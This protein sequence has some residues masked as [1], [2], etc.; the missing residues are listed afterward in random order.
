MGELS[1]QVNNSINSLKTVIPEII[2]QSPDEAC[3]TIIK[4]LLSNYI[5]NDTNVP[6]LISAIET[7]CPTLVQCFSNISINTLENLSNSVNQ[8]AL[9]NLIIAAIISV[10]SLTNI[11]QGLQ[12]NTS[13]STIYDASFLILVSLLMIILI[14]KSQGFNEFLKNQTNVD[15]LFN[16]LDL[17][18]SSYDALLLSSS[19]IEEIGSLLKQ[20][21][22]KSFVK[23]D[24]CCSCS[25]NPFSTSSNVQAKKIKKTTAAITRN[26]AIKEKIDMRV[27]AFSY[28][29][30]IS[31]LKF[32]LNLTSVPKSEKKSKSKSNAN[33]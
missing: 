16:I 10:A 1:V 23:F 3:V 19:L 15:T 5:D 33:F 6:A 30:E 21:G 12:I 14:E 18:E 7:G 11:I 17:L 28:S 27:V 8:Q 25:F 4:C 31:N 20:L 2:D 13:D 26:L 24:K 9:I 32:K 29:T 22:D